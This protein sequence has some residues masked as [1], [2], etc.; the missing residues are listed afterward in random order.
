MPIIGINDALGVQ[1]TAIDFNFTVPRYNDADNAVVQM[2][3]T[4]GELGTGYLHLFTNPGASDPTA[5]LY[6]YKHHSPVGGP[7]D[8]VTSTLVASSNIRTIPANTGWTWYDFT[9]P[10]TTL[11]A[12][13]YYCITASVDENGTSTWFRFSSGGTHVSKLGYLGVSHTGPATLASFTTLLSARNAFALYADYTVGVPDPVQTSFVALFEFN[14]ANTPGNSAGTLA[15]NINFGTTDAVD[16]VPADYPIM[17]GSNSHFKQFTI[18]ISGSYTKVDNMKLYKS[19]GAYVTGEGIQF[20]GS[21]VAST[22]ST[23]DQS[24]PAIAIGLP[25]SANVAPKGETTAGSLPYNGESQSTP[26][27]YSGSRTTLMRFQMITTE[28]TPILTGNQ[29]TISFTYD[30]Q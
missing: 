17:V 9:F 24:D 11:E 5:R 25:S 12:D 22:P 1:S 16:L 8:L 27:Y 29:K 20:S 14:G 4:G 3:S 18:N 28:N 19:A 23:T 26:G 30:K 15:T 2:G 7:V 13:E 21:V 10:S 6:I